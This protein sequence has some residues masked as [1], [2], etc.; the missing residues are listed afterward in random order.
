MKAKYEDNSSGFV[1]KVG[2]DV[3]IRL[4]LSNDNGGIGEMD[5]LK[6]VALECSVEY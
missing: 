5:D 3:E 6:E 1:S 2:E 4:T